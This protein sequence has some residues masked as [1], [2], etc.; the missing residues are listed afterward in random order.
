M[1][2]RPKSVE[3]AIGVH[4][5]ALAADEAAFD[6]EGQPI[7]LNRLNETGTA[8]MAAYEAFVLAPCVTRLAT[9]S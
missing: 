2:S 4:R 3:E 5:A 7:D 8:E 9:C 1:I 6:D